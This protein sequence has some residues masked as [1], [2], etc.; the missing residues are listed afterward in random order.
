LQPRR[1]KLLLWA[2]PNGEHRR[3]RRIPSA[4]RAA[5]V[6][7]QI[8]DQDV[9]TVDISKRG[10]HL[11]GIRGRLRIGSQVSFAHLNKLEQFRVAWVGAENTP[12]AGQVGLAAIDPATS[13]WSDMVETRSEAAMAA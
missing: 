2:G 12:R 10:T 9:T 7:G 4:I 5:D 1:P 11:T 13:F 8:L 3:V 6:N